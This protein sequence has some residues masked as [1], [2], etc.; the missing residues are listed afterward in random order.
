MTAMQSGELD[1]IL[2]IPGVA[3]RADENGYDA[4]L[5]FQADRRRDR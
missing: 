5:I 2:A 3:M 1:V 4:M